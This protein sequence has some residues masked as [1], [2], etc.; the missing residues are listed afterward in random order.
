MKLEDFTGEL[1]SIKPERLIKKDEKDQVADFFLVLGAFYNDLKNLSFFLKEA[2]ELFDSIEDKNVPTVPLGEMAGIRTYVNRL[3]AS[4]VHELLTFIEASKEN[5]FLASDFLLVYEELS[6]TQKERWDTVV[7][8]A[9]RETM[10]DGSNLSKVLMFIRNKV[11][12][13][14]DPKI[15]RA[16]FIDWFF[17]DPKSPSNERAY[18]SIGESMR[19]TKFFYSEAAA[20]RAMR[21]QI[22]KGVKLEEYVGKFEGIIEDLNFLIMDMMKIYLQRRPY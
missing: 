17:N 1:K 7:K 3:L 5:V 6:I 22:E 18:Y 20:D 15:M 9:T 19:G 11:S 21:S 12:F 4:T 2:N 10:E 16:G 13:H 14:Y 8:I